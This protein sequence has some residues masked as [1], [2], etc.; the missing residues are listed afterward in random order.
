MGAIYYI[1]FRNSQSILYKNYDLFGS[2][3]NNIIFK[4]SGIIL[5]KINNIVDDY[6]VFSTFISGKRKITN[7]V[8]EI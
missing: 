5:Q 4:N 2:I 8:F 7:Y 3:V 6:N 1:P